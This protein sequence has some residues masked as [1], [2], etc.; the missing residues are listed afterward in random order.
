MYSTLNSW[1]L[2]LSFNSN[3][4][5]LMQSDTYP[6][7]RLTGHLSPPSCSVS[8]TELTAIHALAHRPWEALTGGGRTV[9][10]GCPLAFSMWSFF[11]EGVLCGF[12]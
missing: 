5:E 10:L 9:K 12:L 3:G 7:C 6:L 2:L 1:S 8:L 4:S 11:L